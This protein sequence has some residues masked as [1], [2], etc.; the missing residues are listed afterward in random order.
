MEPMFPKPVAELCADL[1]GMGFDITDERRG[2]TGGVCLVLEGTV[3]AGGQWVDAFVRIT[4]DRGEWS[5]SVRFHD[6]SQWI[7]AQAWQAYLDNRAPGEP[8][9]A[10]QASFVR[11]RLPEAA[12]VAHSRPGVENDLVILGEWERPWLLDLDL[13]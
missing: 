7:W 4:S 5:I 3:P 11:S 12:A 9:V 8:D 6:M 1:A 10:Q 2:A 13:G